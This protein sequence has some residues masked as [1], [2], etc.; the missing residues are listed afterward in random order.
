MILTLFFLCCQP[1]DFPDPLKVDPRRPADRYQLQ[2][3]GFHECLGLQFSEHT[4]PEVLKVIFRLKNLRRAEGVPGRLAGFTLS[5]YKTDSPVY[6]DD[7]GNLTNWPSS[8]TLVVSAFSMP[9]RSL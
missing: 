1:K 2:G 6:L 4:I 5:N 7:A 9:R 3:C 8:L